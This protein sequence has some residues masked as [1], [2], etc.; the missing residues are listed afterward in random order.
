MAKVTAGRAAQVVAIVAVNVTLPE[1][2]EAKGT[3]KGTMDTKAKGPTQYKLKTIG[4]VATVH[5]STNPF[6]A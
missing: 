4:A 3:A 2:A 5:Q 1:T 6:A